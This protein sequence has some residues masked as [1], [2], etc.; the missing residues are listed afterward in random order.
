[1]RSSLRSGLA[2]LAAVAVLVAVPTACTSGGVGDPCTPEQEYVAHFAGFDVAEAYVE[3]RSFQCATRVCLVNHFQGRVS[4]P[5]GQSSSDLVSCDGPGDTRC[6]PTGKCTA[7]ETYAPVCNACDPTQDPGCTPVACPTGLTCDPTRKVCTCDSATSPT[8]TL[9]GASYACAYFDPS[10]APGG[11]A[12]C[13]GVLQSYLCHAPG[14]CQSASATPAENQGKACCVP[15]TDAPVSVPV[16]GQCD[17][18]MH[19]DAESAVY[20]SCRCAVADGDPPEPDF[21]FCACPSGFSCSEIRPDLNLGDAQLTGKYC[22]R[23]GSAFD[24]TAETCGFVAGNH[25]A[26]CAGVGVQ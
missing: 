10:C 6:G 18:S 8:L 16:C 25:D 5:L 17:T 23:D 9:D 26:P 15:G 3:S 19:R 4:C 14:A 1:M 7:S 12:P 11:A 24:S 13:M 21:N 22:I 2:W 20:C